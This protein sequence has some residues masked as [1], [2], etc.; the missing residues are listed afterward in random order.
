MPSR[1]AAAVAFG[2]AL[3]IGLVV[4]LI[5][6]ATTTSRTVQDLGVLGVY[7]VAPIAAG[8]QV[9]ESPIG[10]AEPV[11]T[12]RLAIGTLGKPGPPLEA[13]VQPANSGI[14][15]GRGRYPGGWVDNGT[16]RDFHIGHIAPDQTVSVCVRNLGGARAYVYGDIDTGGAAAGYLGFRVTTSRSE[17][18]IQ[19]VPIPG[20]LSVK[21]IGAHQRSLFTRLPGA[22]RHASRFRPGGVGPWTFW[23]L[24][25]LLVFAAPVGLWRALSSAVREE[26]EG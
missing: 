22:F 13:T 14:V 20:D 9:C 2:L 8:Q 4:L 17:A 12:L 1:R 19:G 21:F 7:P 23:L 26:R 5:G 6:G 24:A 11:D 25:A 15:L 18:R 10:L 3:G 16:P